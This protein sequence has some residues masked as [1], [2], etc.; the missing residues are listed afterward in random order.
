MFITDLLLQSNDISCTPEEVREAFFKI[1]K[2]KSGDLDLKEFGQFCVN[3]STAFVAV[4][5]EKSK[6][7]PKQ[8]KR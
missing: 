6:A 4:D 8:R 7:S 5:R 2:D 3:T 1:D